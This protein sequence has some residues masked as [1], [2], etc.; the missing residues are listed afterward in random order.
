M[1][2]GKEPREE[3]ELVGVCDVD[4]EDAEDEDDVLTSLPRF[5]SPR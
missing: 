2:S 5:R 4:E 3:R 1:L